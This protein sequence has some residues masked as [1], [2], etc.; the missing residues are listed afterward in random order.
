VTSA[1]VLLA[2]AT[3]SPGPSPTP[4]ITAPDPDRVTPGVAGFLV[5]F[6]LALATIVLLRSMTNHLRKVRYSPD[7]AA[8]DAAQPR[9][10][11]RSA[12]KPAEQ[13]QQ[14]ETPEKAEN[15]AGPAT[16]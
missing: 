15:G 14:A 11:D 6:L 2:T 3:P 5:M 10:Q 12:D 16:P 7:P 8:G 9:R 4:V 13:A 1:W